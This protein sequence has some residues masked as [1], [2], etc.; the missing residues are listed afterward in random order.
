MSDLINELI[1]A[2]LW[3]YGIAL[4]AVCAMAYGLTVIYHKIID[5]FTQEGD[6][7]TRAKNQ[8]AKRH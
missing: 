1:M 5:K 3:Y 6:D 2:S 4:V 8:M 7:G